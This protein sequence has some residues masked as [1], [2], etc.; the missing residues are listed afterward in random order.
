MPA[1][2]GRRLLQKHVS[3]KSHKMK[4]PSDE[5][6]R[7]LL[8]GI[9]TLIAVIDCHGQ[10]EG[11]IWY[12]GDYAGLDFNSGQPRALTNSAMYQRE[13]CAVISDKVGNLMFYTNGQKVWN[14]NGYLM[15][16]GQ[17]LMGHQSATQSAIIAKKPGNNPLYYI[18]TVPKEIGYDGL[19]YSVVD[20][21]LSGGGGDLTG[22][23]NNTLNAS[24]TE[25]KVTA[26]PHAN[27]IDI[28]IITHL[29]NTDAFYAFLLTEQGIDKDLAV[30][31]HSGLDHQGG[32]EYTPGYMK[33]S[34]DGS[35]IG[36]ITRINNSFQLFD[37]DNQTGEV[38]NPITFLSQYPRAYGLEFSPSGNMLYISDYHNRRRIIQFDVTLPP[39]EMIQSG[40]EVGSVSNDFV[41]ALQ[42]APDRKI[43]I[44]KYDTVGS[45]FVGDH[46]LGSIG[47]PEKRGAACDFIEDDFDLGTA[48][49]IW[50]LPTFVQSYFVQLQDFYSLNQCENDTTLFNLTNEVELMSVLWD[51]GDPLSGDLNQ[52]TDINPYHIYTSPGDYT[53]RLISWFNANTDTLFKNITIN[54]T[55]EVNLGEDRNFCSSDELWLQ[56]GSDQDDVL[57]QD[58]ST[59]NHYH[60]K[61]SERYYAQAINQYGC[62]AS[63]TVDL[64]MIESPFVFLGNDTLLQAGELLVLSTNTA[65]PPAH[66]S[67]GETGYTFNV[68]S[69]GTYWASV[70]KDGC[71]GSDTIQVSYESHCKIY[72][73]NAFT[74]NGDGLNDFFTPIANEPIETYRLIIRNRWGTIVYESDDISIAWDGYYKD[75]DPTPDVYSWIIRFTCPYDTEEKLAK[76]TVIILK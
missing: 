7:L 36:I 10:K 16:N 53:V 40:I 1:Y 4:K 62:T 21:T 54:A 76:G 32:S 66:W 28:W 73:P 37:F 34:P 14:K 13:G 19:R 12:F 69:P 70:D 31:S 51:F 11:N 20:M 71:I 27:G 6:Y 30:I 25:E 33:A 52:S 75:N 43:Y 2:A 3:G 8:L 74:P 68:N 48:S 59:E 23:I 41:G 9:F 58:G 44:A 17:S 63:D 56:A 72:C 39:T 55:P 22:P 18:F 15:P 5:F 35:K 45:E 42:I 61:A 60:V 49:C 50:G 64:Q 47:F 67:N 65:Y 57:W 38:S 26:I 46:F 29:W 24:P